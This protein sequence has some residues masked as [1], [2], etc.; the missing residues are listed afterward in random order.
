MADQHT[1]LLKTLAAHQLQVLRE[2]GQFLELEKEYQ[3]EIEQNGVY[4]LLW[5]GKVVAPFRDL[6]EMCRFL[7]MA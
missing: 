3:V 4:K 1:E 5:K 2:E 6:E 7:K